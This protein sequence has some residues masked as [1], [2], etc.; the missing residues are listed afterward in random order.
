MV[1]DKQLLAEKTKL[2]QPVQIGD[3]KNE[4]AALLKQLETRR[5]SY[6]IMDAKMNRIP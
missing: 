2:V 6:G 4:M 3:K 1:I 5:K